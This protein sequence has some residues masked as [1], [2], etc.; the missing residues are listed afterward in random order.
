MSKENLSILYVDDENSI[1]LFAKL[2]FKK[3][4]FENVTYASNGKEALELYFKN[5][6]YDIVFT[7]MIMPEMDGFVLIQRI[8]QLNKDQVIVMVTGMED[9][10][11]LIRA[12]EL[13]VR[14]FIEKP[15]KKSQF[16]RAVNSALELLDL[17]KGNLLSQLLLEQ[18]KLAIDKTTILTKTD[19]AGNITYVND[20]F[21]KI[22]KYSEDE[23]I[24]KNHRII[25]HPDMPSEVFEDMWKTI[26]SNKTWNGIIKNRAKDGSTYIVESTI[27]PILDINDEIIEY[28]GI[29]HDITQ[30]EINKE[31]LKN[32]LEDTST[33][34]KISENLNE[35]YKKGLNE[36][37]AIFRTDTENII[38]YVNDNFCD[39]SGF[40]RDELLGI[41]CSTLRDDS[42]LKRG[43][44]DS[45]K[46]KLIDK[47]LVKIKF[48]NIAKGGSH[49][50]TDTV[51]YPIED[52]DGNTIEHMHIM[53]DITEIVEL[54]YEIEDTQKEVVFTM[55]AIGETR[56]KETG[57]HVKRVAEY[58][59][60]L[61]KL[62]G[63]KEEE[64]ELIKIASPMHDIGKVGIPDS[65]LN[66][67]GKLTEDEFE[68]MKT[69]AE[70]G[71]DMLKG[72]SREILK[73][74]SI[75]AYQHHERWD[76]KGYPNGIIGEDI[77]IYGRI[78][79][80]CDVFD[81]LGSDRCYKKAWELNRILD[82]FKEEQGRQFDPNLMELFLSN[83]DKFLEIRDKYID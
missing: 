31:S 36:S 54:N 34:L 65:I 35:Q 80:I 67:P 59:S 15:I 81:A 13:E 79:S 78:T 49:F 28:I 56:S 37:T 5:D 27:I 10:K 61:A 82:M 4:G 50:Y 7:D 25:K 24:G 55:G 46:K 9:K 73:T 71:Y 19:P 23:M 51:V 62:A 75:I 41:N 83:L 16:E 40:S 8:M 17:R 57:F 69:H 21:C 72:S 68:I 14:Y 74:S 38:L 30:A 47:E 77:H 43:D 3:L 12:I 39:L 63:I 29:R 18:H 6:G 48:D 32:E 52:I 66:K 45:L 44:C 70:I 11:D 42:H 22:S 64:A 26:S 20:L 53:H 76:G 2:L 33:T 60:L 1:V 58:S